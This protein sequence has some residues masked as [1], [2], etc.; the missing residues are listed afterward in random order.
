MRVSAWETRVEVIRAS[1]PRTILASGL[2]EHRIAQPARL[3]SGL[4]IYIVEAGVMVP[5]HVRDV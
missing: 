3:G 5:D 4:D 1:L 2:E